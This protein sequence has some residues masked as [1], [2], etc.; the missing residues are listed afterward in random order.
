VLEA[1]RQNG[2]M[3]A[4]E[5]WGYIRDNGADHR[6][7]ITQRLSELAD[8]Y[9]PPLVY[10]VGKRRCMVSGKQAVVWEAT[11]GFGLVGV[12]KR[13][14]RKGPSKEE[15]RRAIVNFLECLN[16]RDSEKTQQAINVLK[17]IVNL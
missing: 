14:K 16:R 6:D 8:D 7:G 2:P 11:A 1:L 12:L 15:M 3:T 17:S 13:K 5:T 10:R 9:E 4:R